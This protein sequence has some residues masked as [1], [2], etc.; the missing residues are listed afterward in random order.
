METTNA[1]QN[2]FTDFLVPFFSLVGNGYTL[3]CS[4]ITKVMKNSSFTGAEYMEKNNR[5]KLTLCNTLK[6]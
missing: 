1:F 4:A 3:I 2:C 5:N 6:D